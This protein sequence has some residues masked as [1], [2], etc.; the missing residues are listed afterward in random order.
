MGRK[1]DTHNCGFKSLCSYCGHQ[2]KHLDT[3]L[4]PRTS[5]S[6]QMKAVSHRS[7]RIAY[8]AITGGSNFQVRML[9]KTLE[10]YHSNELC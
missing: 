5:R 8:Y 10:W 2:N 4:E 7:R 9:T 3:N 6:I 1:T